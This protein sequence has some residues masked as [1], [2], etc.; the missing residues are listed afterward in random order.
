MRAELFTYKKNTAKSISN[1]QGSNDDEYDSE[2][3]TLRPL[4]HFKNSYT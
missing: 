3:I 2:A 4:K 1:Y